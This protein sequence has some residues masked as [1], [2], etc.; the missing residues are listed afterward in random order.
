MYE[1]Q[2]YFRG[3]LFKTHGPFEGKELAEMFLG[4]HDV[5]EPGV[6]FLIVSKDG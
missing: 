3:R 1:V 6:E 4:H 5:N 2:E